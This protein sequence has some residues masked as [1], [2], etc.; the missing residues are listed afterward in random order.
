MTKSYIHKFLRGIMMPSL[1][2]CLVGT[3]IGN[4]KVTLYIMNWVTIVMEKLLIA[5]SHIQT[6][7]LDVFLSQIAIDVKLI[8]S[9]SNE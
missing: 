5:H 4:L 2:P 3:N 1:V 8:H 6:L 9:P 7:W